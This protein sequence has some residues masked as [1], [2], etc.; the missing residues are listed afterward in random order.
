MTKRFFNYSF[1][2]ITLRHKA[3]YGALVIVMVCVGSMAVLGIVQ[4]AQFATEENDKTGQSQIESIVLAIQFPMNV[5][6]F[7]EV[8][9]VLDSVLEADSNVSS[10]VV[11]DNEEDVIASATQLFGAAEGQANNARYPVQTYA[12]NIE[13]MV[14]DLG[15]DLGMDFDDEDEF[16]LEDEAGSAVQSDNQESQTTEESSAIGRIVLNRSTAGINNAIHDQV[17]RTLTVGGV[18]CLA[19]M[20]I[21]SI[22]VRKELRRLDLLVRASEILSHGDYSHET[23]DLGRDEIG[24]LGRSFE[25]MRGAIQSRGQQLAELNDSLQDKVEERTHDLQIAVEEALSANRAKTDFLANMSHEIRTPMT[26]I[27]GFTELLANESVPRADRDEYV[28]TIQRNGHFLLSI[29]NDILDISKVEAGKMAI[30]RIETDTSGL[31]EEVMSFMRVRAHPKGLD[32]TLR[33]QSEIPSKAMIDP[34]RTRQI[35][36]NLVGNAIKFT[37]KGSVDLVVGCDALDGSVDAP[38]WIEVHDTGIGMSQE[39]VGELF[40]AFQQADETMAR[41]HGGT[42]LGLCISRSL[43]ELQG[44]TVTVR[45]TPGVGSVFTIRIDPGVKGTV[46]MFSPKTLKFEDGQPQ[47]SGVTEASEAKP[48]MVKPL[49]GIRILLA[50]DGPDNQILISHVL[51]KAGATVTIA[52][53][54]KIGMDT[55]LAKKGTPEAFHLIL[56]DMQMPEMDGYTATGL[57]RKQ[58][59]TIP[60]IALTA[61]AMSGD[62]ERCL[63]SGCDEYSTKPIKRKELIAL[64]QEWANFEHRKSA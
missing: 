43:A 59:E 13:S 46:E 12:L 25:Q 48:A 19:T 52:D 2:S 64:C 47:P 8:Q 16:R 33:Y 34:L 29:I 14:M 38:L 37:D 49:E 7:G 55:Y 23:P 44:G 63:D 61:H 58:G 20:F 27:L 39:Q 4:M 62:R 31:I 42:G 17:T 50:E 1:R 9:R 24:D 11:F 18:I 21:G 51:K 54:G 60:I 56:M 45:S 53:N 57:L 6:D 40:Q 35:I 28:S 22:I 26:A 10:C 30:E 15:M 36:T 41:K 32:L 3:I 5:G